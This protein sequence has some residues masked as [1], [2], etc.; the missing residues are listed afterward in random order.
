MDYHISPDSK[1]SRILAGSNLNRIYSTETGEELSE[2]NIAGE[3]T[4][5]IV[6]SPDWKRHIRITVN[7]ELEI[8][9]SD[10]GNLLFT[11][12]TKVSIPSIHSVV[13]S[14][15]DTWL[16]SITNEGDVHVWE[17][18]GAIWS[19]HSGLIIVLQ[20]VLIINKPYQ[21]PGINSGIHNSARMKNSSSPMRT[22]IPQVFGDCNRETAYP[23]HHCTRQIQGTGVRCGQFEAGG[24]TAVN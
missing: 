13:I 4:F 14:P 18:N 11:L 8:F 20:L 15:E 10:N 17:T 12:N 7:S 23:D 19:I 3:E 2:I 24:Q 22:W 5:K 9:N 21:N 16:L 1:A 6:F